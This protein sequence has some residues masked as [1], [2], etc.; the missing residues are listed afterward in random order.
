MNKLLKAVTL[1]AAVLAVLTACDPISDP[2]K[3]GAHKR[4]TVFT[5]G[6]HSIG[7]RNSLKTIRA[8]DPA[9]NCKWTLMYDLPKGKVVVVNS[10]GPDTA[11]AG[12]K[13]KGPGKLTYR[14]P[15]TKKLVTKRDRPTSFYSEHCGV[16][17]S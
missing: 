8:I 9:P 11:K 6:E 10:G 15:Q 17:S 3:D 16:W 7:V 12:V 13:L 14:D 1:A 5:D 4:V 2:G